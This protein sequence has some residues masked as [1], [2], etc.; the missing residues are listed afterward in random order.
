MTVCPR[1]CVLATASVATWGTPDASM[2]ASTPP[3]E[4][5]R[6]ASTTS[7]SD[8]DGVGGP[9]LGGEPEPSRVH[10]DR[11]DAIGSQP[12]WPPS[13]PHSPTVPQPKTATELPGCERASLKMAP[14]P[15]ITPQPIGARSS[16]GRSAS[17]RN[18]LRALAT[19]WVAK[20]DW[21][22]KLPEMGP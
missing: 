7:P 8:S 15:V 20:D 19:A 6:T 9:E 4:M 13:P 1:V 3:P 17:T 21:P 10:V 11:H 12:P 2:A 16:S 18:A 14:A 5:A 22:T